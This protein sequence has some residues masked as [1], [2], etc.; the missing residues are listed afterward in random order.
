[1]S[2]LETKDLRKIYGSGD[3]QVRALDGVNLSVENGEFVAIVGTLGLIG[4]L[5]CRQVIKITKVSD[6]VLVPVIVVLSTIGSYAINNRIS[7][8]YMMLVFG[9]I[10]YLCKKVNLPTAPIILGMLLEATGESGFKNAILM[11]KNTPVMLYYLQRPASLV[12]LILIVLTV[13]VPAIQSVVRMVKS[14][15]ANV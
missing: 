4:M 8:V 10:G 11:A 14:R 9:L 1:M 12:L 15:K 13:V 3:T 6:S 2:I 7:D 5:I